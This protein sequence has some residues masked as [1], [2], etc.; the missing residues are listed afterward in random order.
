[1]IGKKIIVYVCCMSILSLHA[2]EPSFSQD[3]LNKHEILRQTEAYKLYQQAKSDHKHFNDKNSLQTLQFCKKELY[4][5]QE[6]KDWEQAIDKEPHVVTHMMQQSHQKSYD[7][8]IDIPKPYVKGSEYWIL[9]KGPKEAEIQTIKP[10]I[11][12]I[13]PSS[14]K[15]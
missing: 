6:Y 1:M 11:I 14:P 2:M 12:I 8:T 4:N 13:I 15:Y 3:A 10:K 7:I 9:P 5:T